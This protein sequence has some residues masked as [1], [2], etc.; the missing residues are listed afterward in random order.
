MEAETL[1][2]AQAGDYSM[3][4]LFMRA[5]LTVKLVMIVLIVASFWAWAIIIQKL[6]DYRRARDEAEMFDRA[7]WSGEPLDELF[8]K[9]G[10]RSLWPGTKG[11]CQWHDRMAAVPSR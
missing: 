10:C 8:D 7:F 3:W 4:S 6:I 5:T 1:A 2:L 9:I 11:L